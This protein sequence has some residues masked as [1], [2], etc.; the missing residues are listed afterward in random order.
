MSGR[1]EKKEM[2]KKKTESGKKKMER[3]REK[4]HKEEKEN[5]FKNFAEGFFGHNIH[6]AINVG[7]GKEEIKEREGK[8]KR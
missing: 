2:G 5:I 3:R 4:V 7:W 8:K 6:A 1:N